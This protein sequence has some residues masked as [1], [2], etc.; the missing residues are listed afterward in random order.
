MANRIQIKRSA[1]T[2]SPASLNPGELAYSNATGGSGVLFIGSTDGGTVVPIGGVRS[3]GTLTAN[4]ALVANSTSGINQIQIGNLAFVGTTQTISANGSTGTAGYFLAS[5]GASSNLYWVSS[6]SVGVNTA[7]QYTWTNTQTFQNTITFSSTINIAA[8]AVINSTAYYWVGNTT[9][10]PTVTIANTGAISVGNS[11][12]TQTTGQVVVQN[13]AGVSTVNAGTISTTTLY[14]NIIGST[15]N[16]SSS[17]NSALITVGASVIANTSGIFVAN[18]TG[19]VNA[20]SITVGTN[21][22]ANSTQLTLSNIQLSANGGVGSAGQ[23]LASNGATGSPYWKND[24][25]GT[26]TSVATSNGIGGGTITSTGTLYAI[27]NNGIVANSTGIWAKQANGIS[28]D[29]SG[30]NVLANNGIVS[31]SSGI[32]VKNG[33]NTLVVN[34][35]GAFVNSVLSLTDLTLSGNL[36]VSGTFTSVN[37]TSLIIKDN[38]IELAS[39]NTTTDVVDAGW[40]SPAGNSSAIWYAGLARIAAKSTNSAPFFWLFGSNTNPNTSSTIDTSANSGTATLQAYLMPYGNN[41]SVFVVNSTAIQINAN[42]SVTA[43]L[44]ANSLTLTTALVGTSGGTGWNTFT[45]QDLLVGNTS[46]GLSKLSL[47]TE[48]YVLQVNNSLVTWGILDGGTF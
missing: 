21:F 12:T 17:V 26:V 16:L 35:S 25:T 19:T 29:S 5:G 3:P 20:A 43:A 41:S 31:N 15:A 40:Y 11:S 30:I 22:I 4:Q 28:V 1:A 13:T 8:N 24:S 48:G 10:S 33:D 46:N 34:T 42:S 6:A 39:N 36:I 32:S 38:V 44:A 47:G 23:I 2:A 27:A 37:V 18:T 9:T 45:S 14:A 7:A